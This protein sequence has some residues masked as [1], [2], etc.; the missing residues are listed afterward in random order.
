MIRDFNI[1]NNDWNSLY[2]YYSTYLN[3]LREIT[4]S[5]NLK[6]SSS[7]IQVSTQYTDNSQ[8][9]NSV[10]DLIFLQA[11]TE[12]FNNHMILSDLQ[13]LFNHASLSVSIIIEK[14]F[15]QDKKLAIIKNS[16]KEEFVNDLRN[17][18][19][20]INIANIHNCN[21]VNLKSIA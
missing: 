10:L 7:I 11:N 12:E 15:I 3:I 19:S 6:L 5:F 9:S 21:R 8:D 16:K 4:D 17:K 18:I 2:L 20:Y 13:G 14:E 1:R